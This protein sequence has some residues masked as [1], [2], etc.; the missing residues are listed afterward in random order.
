ML[1]FTEVLEHVEKQKLT[2]EIHRAKKEEELLLFL[3]A[4]HYIHGII[5]VIYASQKDLFP[6]F[7]LLK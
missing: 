2:D 4:N 5:F 7:Q 1:L 3:S 6:N